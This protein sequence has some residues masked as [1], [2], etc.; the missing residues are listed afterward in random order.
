MPEETADIITIWKKVGIPE[1][2]EVAPVAVNREDIALLVLDIQNQ[3]CTP[4]PRCVAFLPKIQ[5]LL[6]E[7]RK[8]RCLWSIPLPRQDSE[9]MSGGR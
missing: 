6:N 3:N 4:R 5:N 8:K 2:P 7:D 1:A 9:P